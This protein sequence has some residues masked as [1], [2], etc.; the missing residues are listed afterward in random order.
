MGKERDEQREAKAKAVVHRTQ[1]CSSSLQDGNE[2]GMHGTEAL[3]R[4]SKDR[5]SHTTKSDTRQVK[6]PGVQSK[7]RAAFLIRA[8][9]RLLIKAR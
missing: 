7:P 9:H 3:I 6:P 8:T 1:C 2:A 5:D 4:A